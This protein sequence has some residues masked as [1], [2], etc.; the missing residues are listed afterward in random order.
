MFTQC[1]FSCIIST[2]SKRAHRILGV[3]LGVHKMS[4]RI[5][6]HL[7]QIL[8]RVL[9]FTVS[10]I[11]LGKR[12]GTGNFFGNIHFIFASCQQEENGYQLKFIF[13]GFV[14]FTECNL[15]YFLYIAYFHY[16]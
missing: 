1:V 12:I 5:K 15:T 7:L 9:G 14:S 4:T 13:H 6:L 10:D 11:L 16:L 8:Q 3:D 2:Y